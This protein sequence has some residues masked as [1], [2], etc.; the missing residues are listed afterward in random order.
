MKTSSFDGWAVSEDR[1]ACATRGSDKKV[2]VQMSNHFLSIN[3]NFGFYRRSIIASN[4]LPQHNAAGSSLLVIG[5]D[6]KHSLQR[7]KFNE[8]KHW[9]VS[10]SVMI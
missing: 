2:Q 7:L 5:A 10:L 4:G 9:C 3:K 8:D 1:L 6:Q